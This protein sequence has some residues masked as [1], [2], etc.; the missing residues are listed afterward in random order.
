MSPACGWDR[1]SSGVRFSFAVVMYST[2]SA[3]K[4]ADVT[5]ETGSRTTVSRAGHIDHVQIVGADD[6]IEMRV[7][8]IL[9]G[10]RAPVSEQHAFDV[11]ELQRF[12]QQRIVTQIELTDRKI[13]GRPPVAVDPG[14]LLGT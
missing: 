3:P 10:R 2:P 6:A 13:I 8:E 11:C 14:K 7:N 5:C 9:P 12:A 4:A 1:A